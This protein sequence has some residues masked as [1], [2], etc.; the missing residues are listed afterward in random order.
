V[1]AYRLHT[2]QHY[3]TTVFSG[4]SVTLRHRL[5]RITRTETAAPQET[6]MIRPK[7]DKE[8]RRKH[9]EQSVGGYLVKGAGR[10]APL[11]SVKYLH[12]TGQSQPGINRIGART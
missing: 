4:L 7:R 12:Y 6:A 1:V 11:L 9:R 5:Q 10:G 3:Q 8:R 2:A